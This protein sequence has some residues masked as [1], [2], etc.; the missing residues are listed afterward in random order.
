M[1]IT[2]VAG[3]LYIHIYHSYVHTNCNSILLHNKHPLTYILSHNSHVQMTNAMSAPR[4]TWTDYSCISWVGA[5]TAEMV[6]R[7]ATL[8]QIQFCPYTVN[9]VIPRWTTASSEGS[10][11]GSLNCSWEA[12]LMAH[13]CSISKIPVVITH[14]AP[15]TKE[16]EFNTTF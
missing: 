1:F 14:S 8:V 6:G 9:T 11:S 4:L 2:M 16:K 7:T 5:G 13:H 15:M 10:T 12:Q 3:S